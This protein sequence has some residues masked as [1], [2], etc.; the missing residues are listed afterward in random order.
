MLLVLQGSHIAIS[1]KHRLF[2][3]AGKLLP[4]RQSLLSSRGHVLRL[5]CLVMT[6]SKLSEKLEPG[7]SYLYS[8]DES[9][10]L[11]SF[12]A[13][14]V[15]L[16]DGSESDAKSVRQFVAQAQLG[17]Y[18]EKRLLLVK[19]A[20]LMSDIVQNTLL[21]LLEEPPSSV[22]IVL[23]TGQ[24]QQLLPTVLSRLHPLGNSSATPA[25]VQS[26]LG[27]SSSG[28]FEDQTMKGFVLEDPKGSF[29]K[30]TELPRDELVKL[31]AQEMNF[32]Q[33]Q[34]FV[35]PDEQV[36]SRV[37]L[38]DKAIKKLDANANLKLTVDWLLLRWS[39]KSGYTKE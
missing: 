22:V 15:L 35:T 3:L 38:L 39:D 12:D 26:C 11:P 20:H 10:L 31:L 13:T 18:G 8:G 14:D 30:L 36:S 24:A 25:T 4:P 32:Q 5:E 19:N 21:K 2:P 7:K 1:F 34:L 23:Q 17:A 9:E 6:T 28:L 16:F 27:G 29:V 33:Q 37:S